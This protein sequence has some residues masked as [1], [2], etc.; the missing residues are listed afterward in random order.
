MSVQPRQVIFVLVGAAA[1]AAAALVLTKRTP[2]PARAAPPAPDT[3]GLDASGRTKAERL[4][5]EEALVAFRKEGLLLGAAEDGDAAESDE[6]RD[7]EEVYGSYHPFF[8]RGDLDGDGRLDFAQAFVEK[9]PSGSWFHVA[10]FFGTGDGTFQKPLWV[11][12]AISLA[13]GDLSVERSL[14]IVTPDLALDP[15][16]RWRWEAGEKRFVDADDVSRRGPADEDAPEETPD[17]KPRT[18]V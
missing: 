17:Q 1:I 8:V 7:L 10:V 5:V 14:L 18:R 13:A 15:T 3:R 4:A 12:R 2:R 6:H 9:G 16:R 11:E